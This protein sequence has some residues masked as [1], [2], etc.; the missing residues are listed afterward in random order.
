MKRP[1]WRVAALVAFCMPACCLITQA[2]TWGDSGRSRPRPALTP[3][4]LLTLQKLNEHRKQANRDQQALL[5]QFES[6][7]KIAPNDLETEIAAGDLERKTALLD[8]IDVR[9]K[10]IAAGKR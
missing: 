6:L 10:A 7:V 3:A 5:K 1:V 4:T 9:I 8:A 2:T